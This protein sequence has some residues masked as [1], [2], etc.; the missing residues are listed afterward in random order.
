VIRALV[1]PALLLLHGVSPTR[2]ALH[3]NGRPVRRDSAHDT[4]R[5]PARA[6]PAAVQGFTR[7]VQSPS[8]V[9]WPAVGAIDEARRKLRQL[10]VS[11]KQRGFRTTVYWA[12]FGYLKPNRFSIFAKDIRGV[13]HAPLPPTA[14]YRVWDAARVAAWRR[15]R[16]D[17]PPELFQD[18]IDGVPACAVALVD[19]E[20]AGFIWIYRSGDA[21]RL[22]NLHDG[23]AEVNY[24][25]VL[26]PYRKLG[27]FRG[28]LLSAC[29]WLAA[30]GS[31]TVYAGVHSSNGPSLR[32]FDAAGFRRIGRVSHFALYRPKYQP[33][34]AL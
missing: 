11:V 27:L 8:P 22:F 29:D 10:V 23:E 31:H 6:T 7:S 15:G 21:S 13:G 25:A 1:A 28:V 16:P 4:A 26:E 14:T 2:N 20:I 34:R 33:I 30:R 12:A 9:P 17:L 5:Y 18:A 32:A 24:G 19:G 3:V